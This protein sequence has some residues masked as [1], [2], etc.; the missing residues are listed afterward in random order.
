M[1]VIAVVC[2]AAATVEYS[3]CIPVSAE[4][5]FGI[6]V[7]GEACVNVGGAAAVTATGSVNEY[8]HLAETKVRV[9]HEPY[10]VKT[11]ESCNTSSDPGFAGY[12]YLEVCTP[13]HETRQKITYYADRCQD[14]EWQTWSA[15]KGFVQSPADIPSWAPGWEAHSCPSAISVDSWFC[16]SADASAQGMADLW[17]T[18]DE[19]PGSSCSSDADRVITNNAGAES[20]YELSQSQQA[21]LSSSARVAYLAYLKDSLEATALPDDAFGP[22]EVN[23]TLGLALQRLSFASLLAEVDASWSQTISDDIEYRFTP[24][25]P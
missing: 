9:Y 24:Q 16:L 23:Q 20:Q 2:T 10:K 13:I 21:A 6:D 12:G 14:A 25:K 19:A 18:E 11:G 5:P 17:E 4:G 1:P 8:W 3:H 22:D 7:S 15:V